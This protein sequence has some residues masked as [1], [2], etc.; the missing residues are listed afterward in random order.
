MSA[1]GI[2]EWMQRTVKGTCQ[3]CKNLE[4]GVLAIAMALTRRVLPQSGKM[5]LE[6]RVVK[7]WGDYREALE[8]WMAG[9]QKGNYF[10]PLGSSFVESNRGFKSGYGRDFGSVSGERSNSSGERESSGGVAS[11]VTCFNC[12]EKGH[13]ASE[14]KKSSARPGGSGYAPRVVT[15]YNCGKIGY[16]S[17][18]CTVKKG[19]VSVKKEGVPRKMSVLINESKSGKSGNVAMGLVNGTKTEVLIDFGAELGSVPKALVP[20]QVVLCRD[21]LV[22]GYGGSE[23]SCKSFMSEFIIGGY[24]KAVRAIIDESETPGVSCI[25]PFS[26]TNGEESEAYKYAIQDYVS[27]ENVNMNVLTRSMVRKEEELDK[28]EENVSVN[29]LW[30]VVTPESGSGSVRCRERVASPNP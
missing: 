6:N 12:G 24:R 30:S 18:E 26:L 14:C 2:V 5:F 11:Y 29:D 4:E 23:K 20:E 21:V 25:I 8:D 10:K 19:V 1:S 3:G 15:C 27:G 28:S 16:R 9:R 7:N 13:R 22:K 17:P